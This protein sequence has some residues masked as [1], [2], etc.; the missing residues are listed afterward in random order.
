MVGGGG[1]GVG[2]VYVGVAYMGFVEVWS[3][4]LVSHIRSGRGERG[5][6]RGLSVCVGCAY[7]GCLLQ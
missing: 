7:G 3:I 1:D 6:W 4:V 2:G 5:G